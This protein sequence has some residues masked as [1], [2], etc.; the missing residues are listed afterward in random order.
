MS[1]ENQETTEKSGSYQSRIRRRRILI[2]LGV[3]FAIFL[4]VLLYVILVRY[5]DYE[6]LSQ[7]EMV[8]SAQTKYE[9]FEGGFVAYSLDGVSYIDRNGDVLWNESYEMLHPVVRKCEGHI[10]VYDR[11]GTMIKSLDKLG[12]QTTI[13]TTMPVTEADIAENGSIAVLMQEGDTGH[14]QIYNVA[15]QISASGEMHLS[16]GGYPIDLALSHDGKRLAASAM[17]LVNGEVRAK[18]IYYDFGSVGAEK[19]KYIVATV[20]YSD[21]VM[22]EID[23]VKGDRLLCICDKGVHIFDNKDNPE[24]IENIT[25]PGQIISIVH[26]D[27]YIVMVA[28]RQNEEGRIEETMWIYSLSGRPVSEIVLEDS[29]EDIYITDDNAVILSD[30]QNVSIYNLFGVK[31]FSYSFTDAVFK[32]LST[33]R[34]REYILIRT[35]S[36]ERIKVR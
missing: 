34:Y 26:N 19:D 15:G 4:T 11:Q 7:K 12:V 24:E 23:F 9:E 32:M 1:E 35:G 28:N 13:Y 22:P 17:D 5:T 27:S 33:G 8:D 31:R 25:S 10:V 3:A 29:F 16:S 36:M 18:L 21:T 14:L 2:V 6:S 20:T 30:G